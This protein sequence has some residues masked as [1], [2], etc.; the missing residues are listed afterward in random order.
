MP[1]SEQ[2]LDIV[3]IAKMN[4]SI[5]FMSTLESIIN[6]VYSS[7]NIVVVDVNDYGSEYSLGLQED[8]SAFKNIEYKKMDSS[9]SMSE[10]RNFML[11]CLKGEY[12]AFLTANDTWD[13]CTAQAVIKEF[14]KNPDK[15]AVLINGYL[16]DE[17]KAEI[18]EELLIKHDKSALK[19]LILDNLP[20]M[21]AQIIYRKKG[22]KDAGGFD[23]DFDLLCDADM[24]LRLSRKNDVLLIPE[25]LCQCRI[26]ESFRNFEWKL[27]LELKKLRMKHLDLYLTDKNI[28]L[29]F[30]KNMIVLS[31][32]N[33]LWL[34]FISYNALYFIKAPLKTFMMIIRLFGRI[35]WYI[36]LW[37]RMELSMFGDKIDLRFN[38]GKDKKVKRKYYASNNQDRGAD[39]TFISAA[40]FNV[41]SPYEYA[42]N[43]KI[44]YIKIPEHVTTI[45]KGMFYGCEGLVAVE[46]P[47][48]VTGIEAHAFQNCINLRHIKLAEN[49]RLGKIGDYAF[50]GC[51][52]L[53][54]INLPMVSEIGAYVFAGCQSLKKLW[55]G[56]NHYFSSLIEKIPAYAF[57]GCKSLVSVE[58]DNNSMLEVI[59]KNAFYGCSNLKKI[60]ITG[61]VKKLGD[62]AFAGCSELETVA[63]LNIDTVETIGK[64]AFMHCK[65]LSYFQFPSDLKRIRTRTFY[66]CTKLKSVKIPKK[67]LSI[68]YKAFCNCPMLKE[69]VILNGDVMISAK[70]FDKHTKVYLKDSTDTNH[71]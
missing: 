35:F 66:G 63:I 43:K 53:E 2:L 33:F 65:K 69:A 55:F 29:K 23:D 37:I 62:H 45:K 36:I 48:S 41:K 7:V 6:Q 1:M 14:E 31:K 70:A 8:L 51:V 10:I 47:K 50:A 27:Y 24:L 61:R 57:A 17:R 54:E 67:I 4:T 18:L 56:N 44:Q 5:R 59:D 39:L 16:T 21:S 38:I 28:D 15:N 19:N 58:F 49:S 12:V 46:L 64:G 42:F 52:S 26:T 22:L 60:L 3:I 13:I 40:D 71:I 30:Y 9:S 68:N 32:K 11:E 34:D 25:I 20:V